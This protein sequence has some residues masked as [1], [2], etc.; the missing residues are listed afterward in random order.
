MS[1]VP[2]KQTVT[3]TKSSGELDEW[4]NPIPADPVEYACRVKEGSEIVTD[5]RGDEVVASL[6]VLLYKLVDVGYGDNFAYTNEL[7]ITT[8]GSPKRIDVIRDF[9]GKPLFTRVRL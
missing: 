1:L 6:T 5:S 2:L 8:E 7:G 3:I 9:G 4:G